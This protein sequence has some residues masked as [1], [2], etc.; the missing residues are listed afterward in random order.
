V[1]DMVLRNASRLTEAATLR[2]PIAQGLRNTI[3]KFA[4]GFP[5]LQHKIANQLSEMDIA[6]PDSPLSASGAYSVSGPAAGARWP[7]RLPPGAA[8]AKFTAIGPAETVAALAA[9]Y[10]R[11]VVAVPATGGHAKALRLI[12]P[13]GYVGFAGDASEG[14]DAE[15]YLAALAAG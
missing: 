12:R 11:L 4:T 7:D 1:G 3:V 14:V 8:G 2:N 9:K 6:Y 10:P 5:A 13:D 15:A